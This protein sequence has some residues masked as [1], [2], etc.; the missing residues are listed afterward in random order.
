VPKSNSQCKLNV[1]K[2]KRVNGVE[3]HADVAE[4]D[5]AVIDVGRAYFRADQYPRLH[6]VA[7]DA[8]RFLHAASQRYELIVGDVYHGVRSIPPHL[9]TIEFFNL[10]RRR[11]TDDG[12]YMMNVC[13]AVEGEHSAVFRAITAT[14]Q[15]AFPRVYVFAALPDRPAALQN[16]ILVASA[17]DLQIASHAA[18]GRGRNAVLDR[19]FHGYLDPRRYSLAAAP[20]LRDDCNPLEYLVAKSLSADETQGPQRDEPRQ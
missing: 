19:F 15:Q 12:V 10:V 5:P 3:C 7:D 1:H 2:Q 16:V 18:A 11:L 4:I 14:L 13:S 6:A 20:I 17:R 9:A 8:R